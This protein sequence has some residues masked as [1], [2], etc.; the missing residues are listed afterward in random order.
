MDAQ[1]GR[2]LAALEAT[3]KSDN[4]YVFFSADHGLALGQH[5]LMG[6]QNL[7]DHSVRVPLVIRGPGVP[8]DRRNDTR[9]YLQDDY[10]D[11]AGVGGRPQTGTRAVP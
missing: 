3:G 9:V 11:I 1:V 8:T 6:K 10:G 4:T 5:G 2:I 7:F